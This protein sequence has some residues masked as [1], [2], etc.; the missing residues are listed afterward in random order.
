MLPNFASQLN[1]NFIHSI[2][3]VIT[4]VIH[5]GV[6]SAAMFLL[7]ILQPIKMKTL[8]VFMHTPHTGPDCICIYSLVHEQAHNRQKSEKK[9]VQAA[10]AANSATN[11]TR[12]SNKH[13]ANSRPVAVDARSGLTSTL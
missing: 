1:R 8:M 11:A 3:T 2:S 12:A 9:K 7:T 5:A 10:G 13:T 6:Y 4:F